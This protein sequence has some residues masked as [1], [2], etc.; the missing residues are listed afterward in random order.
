MI[1]RE[2]LV[3]LAETAQVDVSG[4]NVLGIWNRRG[5]DSMCSTTGNVT[6][7]AEMPYLAFIARL[8][9]GI[10]A[11]SCQ[12]KRN[13]LSARSPDWPPALQH[14]CTEGRAHDVD[15]AGQALG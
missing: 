2:V 8:Y 6:S 15:S 9:L 13:F 14:A 3:Y 1:E 7:Q 5:T 11:T 4:F 12:A 10:E